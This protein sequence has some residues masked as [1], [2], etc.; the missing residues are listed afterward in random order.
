MRKWI[1]AGAVLLSLC[2]VVALALVNLNSLLNRN[3]DYLLDQA[4]QAVGRKLSVGEIGVTLWG[5]VGARLKNF[6]LSDDP[7]FSSGDFVR[8]EDLQVNLKL[9]PLLRK[10]FQ[11]KRLILHRPVIE[12]I[13]NKDGAFNFST[14]A[15]QPKEEKKTPAKEE[16][17]P[18][19]KKTP[20]ALLVSLVD[21]SG[22][23]IHYLDRK[24]GTDLRVGQIDLKVEDLDFA[25]PFSV[26]LAA[27]LFSEKQNI[28]I[29]TRVGPLGS[30]GDFTNVPLDG[31]ITIDPIDF[32]KLKAGVPAARTAS[33]K[34]LELAGP[35]RLKDTQ[36]KGTL[37]KLALKGS[38]EGTDA[39]VAFGK[40][41][42]KT[43][44]IPLVLSTDAQ[45][46]GNSIS[47]REAKVKLN[48]LELA[49][50][51][52]VKLGDVPV[53]NLALDSN[54]I[55]LEGWEKIIPLIQDYQ[56]SGNLELHTTLQG[57][58]GKGATPQIQGTLNLSGVS[59][60][61]PQFGK[62]VKDL[63]A[64]ILFTGQRA[65]LKDTT[66]TLGN[67]RI[68]L[69]AQ[70]DR[71]SP[72]TLSYKLS[73]PELWPA[74][75]QASLPD[76]RKGDVIKNLSSEGTLAAKNGSVLFQGKI[77][78][79]QGTLY[80]I[81]YKDL[82]T[83]LAV[84]N[85]IAN[86][87]NLRV[88]A[89]SG[90]LQAEGEYAFNNPVPR[91]SLASKVQGIDLRELYRSL[92]PKAQRD[93]QG[94][95]NADMKVSGGG[96]NWEDIKPNLRGQG[97]AEVVQGALLNFNI[98]EGVLSGVTGVPGLTSLISPQVRKKYPETF[99]A[100]DT[101][102]KELKGLFTL[103]D[104]RMNVKDLRIAAAD[105]TVQGNGWV[106][107]DRR[108]D[109]Q[110]L[111]VLSQRLS[112]DLA[113]SVRE[114]TYAFNNQNQFEVPFTLNGTLPNARPKPDTNYLS[115][116][117]Q[118]GLVRRG[119][120]ELERRIFG[121]KQPPPPAEAAPSDPQKEKKRAPTED[122]IRKGL[123]GLFKR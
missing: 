113:H 27:A 92:D 31:K 84:E 6:V 123:E 28:K 18:E 75:Y 66:F 17:K 103:A 97:V 87:R 68:R 21:I 41:F 108:V 47:F 54:R 96:K 101:E 4:Q 80:K 13:R 22:G 122:L 25:Q 32:D 86:I 26:K 72:L 112:A 110:S 64:R 3:K 34:D 121:K 57:K 51:G 38:L 15:K 109:F 59:A 67:S 76:E 91:F 111:L 77:A 105:Y 61:P 95:L 8:A 24:A 100:K 10:E 48:N 39:N 88:N 98:A 37:N 85:N 99:E 70:I 56:L 79:S 53:L 104:A 115:K 118:R 35:L 102:F 20:P 40:S 33:P 69:A 94:R 116:M 83:S 23:D 120:E 42:R 11:V 5:G 73:T 46:A 16:P 89:L 19:E 65:D 55:S 81:G 114:I 45:Y 7:A 90:S 9:L 60:K 93:I 117:I 36:V 71:F 50:K 63:D 119:T 106:D 1:I 14:I 44:G 52:D 78:S 82:G 58:M 2:G 49:G 29:Q 30:E 107:F 74:D 43:S 12:I 62:P